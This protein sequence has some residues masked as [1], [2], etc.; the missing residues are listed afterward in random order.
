[1]AGDTAV[2]KARRVLA[3]GCRASH[4]GNTAAAMA[5]KTASRRGPASASSVKGR[6]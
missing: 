5:A 4:A 3:P 6:I 1:M 2:E